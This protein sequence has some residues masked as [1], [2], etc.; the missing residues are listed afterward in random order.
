MAELV[1]ISYVH[2]LPAQKSINKTA[3]YH[4]MLCPRSHENWTLG[5][6]TGYKVIKKNH[7]HLTLALVLLLDTLF[8]FPRIKNKLLLVF[9]TGNGLSANMTIVLPQ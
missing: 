3:A 4:S 9:P 8:L 2:S 7:A 1:Q 6:Q 5:Q